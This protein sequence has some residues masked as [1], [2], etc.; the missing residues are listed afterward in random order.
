MVAANPNQRRKYN[1]IKRIL[2]YFPPVKHN[3]ELTL[4]YRINFTLTKSIATN[5]N[6][7]S[8]K[9][10]T[11][12]L[13]CFIHRGFPI[14]TFQYKRR[15]FESETLINL[16]LKSAN[17]CVLLQQKSCLSLNEMSNDL[18]LKWKGSE[19]FDNI[20]NP[21]A[22]F[23]STSL[24]CLES[25]NDKMNVHTATKKINGKRSHPSFEQALHERRHVFNCLSK[26]T[27]ITAE[28]ERT[29][30]STESPKTHQSLSYRQDVEE[31]ESFLARK[32]LCSFNCIFSFNIIL[33]ILHVKVLSI[34][35]RNFAVRY[36]HFMR[37]N[38][39]EKSEK[40]SH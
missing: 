14:I 6:A 36:I 25:T 5:Q 3:G 17:E 34:V 7:V 27:E 35:Q 39:R 1:L 19:Q 28:A 38:Q 2:E 20:S 29:I 24:N 11:K 21:W 32:S 16:S 37:I 8:F 26:E 18:V 22:P 33:F 10:D 13:T 15:L 12:V 9:L 40:A 31:A 30:A 23:L 4:F